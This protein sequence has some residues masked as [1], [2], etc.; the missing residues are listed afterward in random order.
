MKRCCGLVKVLDIPV[1][2]RCVVPLLLTKIIGYQ[3]SEWEVHRKTLE[4]GGRVRHGYLAVASRVEYVELDTTK[5]RCICV[6]MTKDDTM[7]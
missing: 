4:E 2:K 7:T 5:R 3:E 1:D 6:H